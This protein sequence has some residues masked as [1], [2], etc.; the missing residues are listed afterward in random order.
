VN[1]SGFRLQSE[2]W[3]FSEFVK[4]VYQNDGLVSIK[5]DMTFCEKFYPYSCDFV[6]D[7]RLSTG[8]GAHFASQ[9]KNYFH[10]RLLLYLTFAFLLAQRR[11]ET[12]NHLHKNMQSR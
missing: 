5:N 1:V 4:R 10:V 12:E 11:A 7:N 6:L 8:A 2:K 3:S 9:R